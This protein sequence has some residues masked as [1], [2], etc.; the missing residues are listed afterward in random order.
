SAPFR[1]S[2]HPIILVTIDTLRADRLGSYGSTLRLTPALDRFAQVST[3]F[4]A[5]VTQVPL[6]L[7][8][9][10]TILTGLHPARHGV[11]TNDGF[12][13]PA[14]VPT[15]VETLRGRGYTTVAFIGGY[16][17]RASCGLARGFDLYDDRFLRKAGTVERSADDVVDAAL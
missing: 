15:V 8:A 16:P 14:D 4:A 5:A 10:A 6:T 12:R 9:H 13:L 17:L 7:P 2:G 11:R 1:L 3:R